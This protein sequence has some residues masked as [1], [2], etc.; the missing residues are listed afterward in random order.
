MDTI[1]ICETKNPINNFTAEPT[2][3]TSTSGGHAEEVCRRSRRGGFLEVT[4]RRSLEVLPEVKCVY[5]EE[6]LQR[7]RRVWFE[8]IIQVPL[9]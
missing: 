5:A 2:Q 1:F 8:T 4:Q 6:G 3:Y 9:Q 7:K